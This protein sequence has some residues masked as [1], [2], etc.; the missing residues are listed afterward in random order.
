MNEKSEAFYQ[1]RA[2][3]AK[4]LGHPSRLK[5]VDVLQEKEIC[6]C[7]LTEMVGKKLDSNFDGSTGW[8]TTTVKLDLEARGVIERIP[9]SSPQ[10]LRL[11]KK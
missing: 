1:R 11:V 10:Q 2:N 8:Y 6:V 9:N 3:I 7:E 4:A 5:I